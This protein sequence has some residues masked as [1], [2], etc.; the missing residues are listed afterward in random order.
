MIKPLGS[1]VSFGG[2]SLTVE[3]VQFSFVSEFFDRVE[4]SHEKLRNA[5]NVD[6]SIPIFLPLF[7]GKVVQIMTTCNTF[8]TVR[9]I[10]PDDADIDNIH[11]RWDIRLY[12]IKGLPNLASNVATVWNTAQAHK[13]LLDRFQAHQAIA[14]SDVSFQYLESVSQPETFSFIT[15]TGYTISGPSLNQT[16]TNT[17]IRSMTVSTAYQ[18]PSGQTLQDFSM[19]IGQ[20]TLLPAESSSI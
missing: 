1:V 11:K 2:T 9:P 17:L 7:A 13:V 20:Y 16:E 4:F 14:N 10:T 15:S 18:V 19:E 8:S 6:G 12:S 3:D 5:K